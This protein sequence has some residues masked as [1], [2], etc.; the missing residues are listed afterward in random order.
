[1]KFMKVRICA[2]L[3]LLTV[4]LSLQP[5]AVASE[6]LKIGGTGGDLGT[7][8]QLGDAFEKSNPQVTV[9]VLPSFGSGGGIKAVSSGVI[10]LAISAR[11]L[12]DAEKKPGVVALPYAKT[13]IVAAAYPN[14]ALSGLRH[15]ELVKIY[16]SEDS[17]WPNGNNIRLV[18]R[19]ETDSDTTIIKSLSPEFA[20]ALDVA[21]KRRGVSVGT[22]DQK[23]AELI[24]E[25][26]G[27]LGF[28][29]LSVILG[30]RRRLKV[31]TLDDITPNATTIGNGYPLT[32]T[33]L[34]IR[35]PKSSPIAPLFIAFLRSPVGQSVLERTGHK[36]ILTDG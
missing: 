20:A 8:R 21:S 10:D 11:P 23:T 34:I 19:P 13:A 6:T 14:C 31:L 36:T 3:F 22:S 18:L 12:K 25:L 26:P 30:E 15:A 2:P 28:L 27:G 17:K 7:M 32:K 1:M 4:W 29:S 5:F 35:G 33:F 9:K 16:R 24:E